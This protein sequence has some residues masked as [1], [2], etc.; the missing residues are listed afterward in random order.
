MIINISSA[1]KSFG[2]QDLFEN[3]SLTIKTK[4]KVAII[5]AN[6]VGK[7]TLFNVLAKKEYLDKG[8]LHFKS[9]IRLGFLAQINLDV[10][11][12]TVREYL[13]E[14]YKDIYALQ[15]QLQEIEEK[16]LTDHDEKTLK[17]YDRIQTEFIRRGGY[18]IDTEIN[19][20]MTQ[21][22][23]QVED[24]ERNME[25]FSGGQITR[26]GFIKLLLSKPDVLLL[27]E[28]TNH[29]DISTIEW[30][31]GYLRGYDGTVIIISHD[32][33]F[34]DRICS[35]IIEIEDRVATR[36]ES[37]Y[38]N[39]IALKETNLRQHNIK[40][41]QQQKEIQRLEN[42]ILRFKGKSSKA[43]FAK[44]KEKYLERMDK[45]EEKKSSTHQF[46]AEFTPKLRGG[47]EVLITQDL[48]VGYDKPLFDISYTFEQGKRYAIVGDNGTGKSTF[49]KT[50]AGKLLPL[51]GETLFGHQ[52]EMGYFDQ[53]LLEFSM[54]KTV[55][56]ELW[57]DYPELDHTEVR[58]ALGR[59]LF[60]GEDVFKHVSVLSGG[61]R[62][63]LSLVKLMLSGDNLLILD[64]PTNH[65]DIQGK[66]ALEKS[67]KNYTGTMIF[68]SH[69]RYFIES[70]ATDILYI[71]E[72][73]ISHT[74]KKIEAIIQDEKE[75][76]KEDKGTN[77]EKY[78]DFKKQQNRKEKIEI[79]LLE[80]EEQLNLYRELRFDPDYYHDYEKMDDLNS[81]IDA[82]INDIKQLEQEWEDI[83]LYLEDT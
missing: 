81:E 40:Y 43:S 44:S 34:I 67:L 20:L 57:D 72:G 68:V 38:T 45:L 54:H 83:S 52:I 66:E 3:L 23:F 78:K 71:K 7:T 14:S 60:K 73:A 28:P 59:F 80:L 58:S 61:E 9:N 25:T 18:N 46:K 70:L 75:E 29:L 22:G 82:I 16:M 51:K 1:Y 39:Y 5:G 8:E 11:P 13:E 10:D 30:L 36:Y 19:T 79:D 65:L 77:K 26:L 17:Q 27:D 15:S 63:R 62:V 55:L 6:G 74:E 21:F 35:V 69:D 4:E 50:I 37:N 33:L 64:E 31:E 48:E 53:Q 47:K 24:L 56:E 49:L 32:R 2:Q 42:V 76:V 12:I 41:A